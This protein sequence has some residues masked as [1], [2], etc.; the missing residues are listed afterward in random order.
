MKRP[1]SVNLELRAPSAQVERYGSVGMNPP[2]HCFFP[3][4][5]EEASREYELLARKLS[6][7]G[8]LT[9]AMHRALSSYVLQIDS[10]IKAREAGKHIPAFWF[11]TL[12]KA[13]LRLKLEQLEDPV[14]G[15]APPP[16][17]FAHCGFSSR[18]RAA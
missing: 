4:S 5:T 11:A 7:A 10:I 2:I 16:N 8:R 17:K 12:D 15:S 1:E 18:S 3:L 13:R 6:D 14:L 9:L